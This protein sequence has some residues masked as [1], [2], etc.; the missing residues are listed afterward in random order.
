M[1]SVRYT[2]L[3]ILVIVFSWP[4]VVQAHLSPWVMWLY[5]FSLWAVVIV[6]AIFI[7]DKQSDDSDY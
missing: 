4:V 6:V 2:L 7:G 1:N 5:P 3:V